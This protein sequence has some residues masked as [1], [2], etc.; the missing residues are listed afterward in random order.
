MGYTRQRQTMQ[1]QSRETGLS[2][3]CVPH[4]TSF[5][6]LFSF[7]LS[8]SCVPYVTSF[9]GL[10][11][12]CLSLSCVPHVASFSGLFLFWVTWGTQDKEKQNKN[13]PGKLVR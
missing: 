1:K 9:S 4:V 3:S 10:F 13:N 2:L 8:L 12:H 6:G 11:L 7:C 5:S